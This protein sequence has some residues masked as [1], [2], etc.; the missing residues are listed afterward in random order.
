M[1]KNNGVFLTNDGHALGV[2]IDIP[3]G[4]ADAI[5]ERKYF[6]LFHEDNGFLKNFSRFAEA[7]LCLCYGRLAAEGSEGDNDVLN[8]LMADSRYQ[9]ACL[10]L[11][12]KNRQPSP[13]NEETVQKV[14]E[15]LEEYHGA[16]LD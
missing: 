5:N 2:S 1:N 3:S 6:V 16:N 7:P 13:M 10:F 11:G 14:L 4:I 15:L 8:D 9:G 12:E